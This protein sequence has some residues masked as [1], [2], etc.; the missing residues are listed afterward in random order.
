MYSIFSPE[1]P[2]ATLAPLG[3]TALTFNDCKVGLFV[4]YF[5]PYKGILKQGMI[6]NISR[7]GLEIRFPREILRLS[8]I[9]NVFETF[10]DEPKLYAVQQH[11]H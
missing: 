10:L 11:P 1:S 6:S 4:L 9:N 7:E 8:K 5:W 3:A 2:R